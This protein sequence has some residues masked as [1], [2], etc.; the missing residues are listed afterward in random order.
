VA[1]TL[2]L[3][4]ATD[5]IAIDPPPDSVKDPVFAI[6]NVWIDL[7]DVQMAHLGLDERESARER[8]QYGP[9]DRLMTF[10][11]LKM[12]ASM[13]PSPFGIG[14]TEYGVI[15]SSFTGYKMVL[16]DVGDE[17]NDAALGMRL[18]FRPKIWGLVPLWRQTLCREFGMAHNGSRRWLVPRH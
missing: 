8:R 5:L 13:F 17:A 15:H 1:L 10:V 6:K 12:A 9:C 7:Y 18:S 2:K 3:S 4:R 11:D 16:K 14:F